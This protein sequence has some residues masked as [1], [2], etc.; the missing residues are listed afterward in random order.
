MFA[1]FSVVVFALCVAISAAQAGNQTIEKMTVDTLIVNKAEI[2]QAEIELAKIK[3]AMIDKAKIKDAQIGQL[4]AKLA[5][6]EKA[7]FEYV[8]I[9]QAEVD[10]LKVQLA[11]IETANI[12]TANI[13]T[14]NIDTANI[15]TANIN[16]ANIGS[17]GGNHGRKC[18]EGQDCIPE[19]KVSNPKW[20]RLS[21]GRL[22]GVTHVKGS[23]Q[24]GL[25]CRIQ[26]KWFEKGQEVQ[27]VST[28]CNY[29][30]LT[31]SN[32]LSAAATRASKLEKEV[33]SGAKYRYCGKSNCYV[34]EHALK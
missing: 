15:N 8:K 18:P 10:R 33:R 31:V 19:N 6:F 34:C 22:M 3:K 17:V 26:S 12:N 21:E 9:K 25:G 5:Q 16:Q 29:D 32:W 14:A 1:L 27:V 23:I 13:Q 4:R 7:H 2:Q 28:N 24:D 11:E 20:I 30:N